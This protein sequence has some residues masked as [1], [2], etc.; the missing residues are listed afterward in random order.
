[1]TDQKRIQLLCVARSVTVKKAE[2]TVYLWSV[3]RY[4]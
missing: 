3:S 4:F 1:M 2:A